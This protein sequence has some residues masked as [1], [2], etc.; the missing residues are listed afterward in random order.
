VRPFVLKTIHRD[1]LSGSISPSLR[2]IALPTEESSTNGVAG[3]PTFYHVEPIGPPQ[4]A[5][6]GASSTG[7]IE[8]LGALYNKLLT[9]VS[10][11]CSLILDIA[12]RALAVP[13]PSK[14]S[15]AAVLLNGSSKKAG[16]ASEGYEL[17]ASVIW[18]EIA[19]RLMSELGH[20]IFAAGQPA[21]FHRVG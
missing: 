1:V 13:V 10:N 5:E 12:E 7:E 20:I 4:H 9:F 3:T 18:D 6:H 21:A 11:D 16:A 2:Q 15:I 19:S 14:T 8:P 17:L